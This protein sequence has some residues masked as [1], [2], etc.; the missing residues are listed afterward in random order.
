MNDIWIIEQGEY[1]DYRVVGIYS[2]EKIANNIR[3]RINQNN[4]TY[5]AS[6]NKRFLDYGVAELE[7]GLNSYWITLHADGNVITLSNNS[8][9]T[10]TNPL[11]CFCLSGRKLGYVTQEKQNDAV[12]GNVWAK[13]EDQA[14]EIANDFRLKAIE[15]GKIKASI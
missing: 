11:T 5:R 10:E 9:F 12:A 6:V 3:D 13:D 15:E 1:E 14:K 4:P 2:S 8:P 7:Q